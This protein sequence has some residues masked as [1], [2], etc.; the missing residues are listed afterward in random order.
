[1]PNVISTLPGRLV[2]LY[3]LFAGMWVTFSDRLLAAFIP[4]PLT[5]GWLQTLKGWA[6][7]GISAALLHA[8]LRRELRM[9]QHT[10]TALRQSEQ[11]YRR[12]VE[13]TEEGIWMID[14]DNQTIFVNQKMADMLG[15]TVDEMRGAPLFAFTD[16]EGQAI[17]KASLERRRQGIREQIEAKFRRRDSGILWALVATNPVEDD[18]GRYAGALAMVTD[19]TERKLAERALQ[20]SEERFRCLSEATFEGI[21][22]N[23][24]G[25]HLDVNAAFVAMMGYSYEEA[26]R[27]TALDFTAPEYHEL[28]L[29][30][31]RS[32][33]EQPYET[34]DVR[35]DGSRFPAEVRGRNM[36][37]RGRMV[38][39]IA[40]RDITER[41]QA[42]RALRESEE[43]FRRLSEA[44][45][46]G[47]V[48]HDQEAILEVNT[49]LASM[50]GYTRAEMIGK[51]F[52]HFA[53]PPFHERIL[54]NVRSEYRGMYEAVALHKD[55]TEIPVELHGTSTHYQNRAAWV[56][57]VRDITLRKRADAALHLSEQRLS[58]IFDTVGD[59]V[60]LLAVEPEDSFRFIAM[61]RTG[62][63]ATGLTQ[64]QVVGKR[65]EEVL[66]EAAHALVIDKYKEAIRQNKTVRWEEV[67][68][69]PT[70]TLYGE[71]AVT[72]AWDTAGF[73]THL[74]GSVHDITGIRRAEAALRQYAERLSILHEIDQSILAAHSP[75]EVAEAALRRIQRLV[76]CQRASL[77]LFDYVADQATVLVVQTDGLN[78][79]KSGARFA[80]KDSGWVEQLQRDGGFVV[81]DIL[82]VSFLAPEVQALRA[83]GIRSYMNLPL[84]VKDELIG[85][86]NLASTSPGAFLSEH[87]VIASEVAYQLA[88][89]MQSA[90]LREDLQRHAVSLEQRVIERTALLQTANNDLEAFSYSVSHDLRAPLRS[91]SGFAEIIARRHRSSLNEE[92]QHYLDNIVEASARMS[93]LIDDLLTYARLGRTSVR[94]QPVS[95]HSLL[96]QI[97]KD[98]AARITETGGNLDLPTNLP[99]VCGDPTLLN[100]IF[101]NLFGNALTYHRPDVPPLVTITWRVEADHVVIGVSDNGIGVP[102]EHHDKIFNVFQRLHSEDHYPGTGIGLAI[103]K[104]SVELLSGRVW[105]ESAVGEGS[106]FSVQLSKE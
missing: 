96:T 83:E 39:V 24:Q 75:E 23:D 97:V 73:C 86:F 53:A 28:V 38:R 41:K 74:I 21:V 55:G 56:T 48:I 10:E 87:T 19:I 65:V 79:V 88:I 20:E 85:A 52:T 59:V 45:F 35:K 58:L 82:S 2:L 22:V 71:V 103:V 47:I 16:A 36:P 91:V 25:R 69:Y 7:V 40:V 30:K 12:I 5:V 32:G 92:G 60:F 90:R 78:D 1:M 9:R 68:D 102:P 105:V 11:R 94:R 98:L 29:E 17:A 51:H 99:V 63:N 15:Y 61:N 66:P 13:T 46:E 34:I 104:K 77:T 70:G 72:P 4:D 67:S 42:E 106:T 57:A 6:F 49:T 64:E 62:L 37:Y 14:A 76:P 3:A 31:I 50:L 8:L 101:I 84:L 44:T 27:M 33:D 18:Q 81:D 95:L 100:Q 54:Q 26:A 89:A 93:R 80:L 43:R